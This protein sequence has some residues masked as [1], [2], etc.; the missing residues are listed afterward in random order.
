MSETLK[1]F[2]IMAV[3]SLKILPTRRKSSGK[4]EIYVCL[5]HRKSQRYINTGIEI[6]DEFQF[7]KGAVCY[8]KDARIMNQRLAYILD[9]YRERLD[10]ITIDKYPTCAA[11]KEV[12][13]AEEDRKESMTVS[14]L[15]EWRIKQL[16]E[17]GRTSY[18]KMNIYS[19]K[20]VVSILGDVVIDYL[21]RRDISALLKAMQRRGYSNGNI[22]M[23]MTHFKAALN[24]AIDNDLVKYEEHPFKGFTMP[25]SEP[26]LMDITQK[27]LNSII[28]AHPDS[29]R[30]SLA[31]D[32][33]LLS[34]YLGGINLADLVRADLSGNTLSYSRLKSDKHKTGNKTTAITIQPEARAIINQY[35]GIDGK[36]N[37]GFGD[38]EYSSVQ[39]YIGKAL[40]SLA[41]E[42]NIKSDFSYY[43]ARK[44]FAQ[45][46]FTLNIK[47]EVIEYCIG[48][49]MKTN[50]P[51][52]NY[53]RV[54]QK[55]ADSAIRKVIDYAFH[56]EQFAV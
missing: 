45:F 3:L 36:L 29:K 10:K 16:E 49:S 22:Q 32:I 27:Q 40:K 38:S 42:M 56:P 30:L 5:T 44:T 21:T 9:M 2:A 18:I 51:I 37:L 14:A 52:Y 13:T 43:S 25:Q 15:F 35:I 19:C 6:D 1:P 8:R 24:L 28:N 31:R 12:L 26:R 23:R 48:Q 55:Q 34:F 33:F 54:M 53:V 39:R 46:G 4:L 11:L 17:E 20:V 7:E 50:R 41:E 47:T